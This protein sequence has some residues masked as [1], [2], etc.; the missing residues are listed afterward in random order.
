MKQLNMHELMTHY[1]QQE[2]RAYHR[3]LM[4]LIHELRNSDPYFKNYNVAK[5]AVLKMWKFELVWEDNKWY[6]QWN[7]KTVEELMEEL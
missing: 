7:P 5:K 1:Y 6:F 3:G 4:S 2:K